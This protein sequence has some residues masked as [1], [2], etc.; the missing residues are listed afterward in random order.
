MKDNNYRKT[1]GVLYNYT[2]IKTEIKNTEI[3]IQELKADYEG[4]SG[5]SYEERSA[6]TN[7]FNSS[8]ENELLRKEKLIKKLTREK[9]SKQRL[10]DKIDNALDPLDETEKKII[11]YRCIKGYSWAKVGVLLNIDGDYC[12]K[13]MRKALSK[14]TSQIWIKEKFQ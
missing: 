2:D 5:V 14:I 6:P 9:N 4:V 13:I 8:V 10:I 7:K 1:E 3:D 12:G 11:E